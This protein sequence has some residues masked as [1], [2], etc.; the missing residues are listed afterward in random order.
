MKSVCAHLVVLLP[1]LGFFSTT[2]DLLLNQAGIL[3]VSLL[4][5]EQSGKDISFYTLTQ[6][7]H[8]SM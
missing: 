8:S 1:P 3:K 2:Q 5:K 4:S 6:Q 7:H